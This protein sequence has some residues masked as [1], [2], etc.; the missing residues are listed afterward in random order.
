MGELRVNDDAAWV[1]AAECAHAAV[2][3]IQ[4]AV[5]E[6]V[7]APVCGRFRGRL[8]TCCH[9][10]CHRSESGSEFT[11]HESANTHFHRS[12]NPCTPASTPA[13]ALVH[14]L[15]RAIALASAPA[16]PP[17]QACALETKALN[18][19]RARADA[20]WLDTLAA[21]RCTDAT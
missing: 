3:W 1:V 12:G 18:R 2:V 21:S 5:T 4:A 13:H 16:V 17:S 19:K 11:T 20:C 14:R 8:A 7:E 9:C 15:S 10:H 6:G